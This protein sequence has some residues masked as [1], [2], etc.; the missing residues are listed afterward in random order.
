MLRPGS[1][2]TY[3]TIGSTDWEQKYEGDYDAILA[4]AATYGIKVLVLDP[5]PMDPSQQASA[6][7]NDL[8]DTVLPWL[9]ADAAANYPLVSFASDARDAV[10]GD[11]F[12]PT[13]PCLPDE[14]AAMGCTDGIITVRAPD[15]LHFCLTGL[16]NQ[17]E[18]CGSPYDPGARR[19][20]NAIEA[21]TRADF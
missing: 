5:P 16:L 19:F 17:K 9:R 15:G 12:T 8:H 1:T 11:T 20:G 7:R 18:P 14:T 6:I 3:L 21:V 13:M 10:G 4:L 2:K